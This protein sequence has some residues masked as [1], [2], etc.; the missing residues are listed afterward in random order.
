VNLFV[1]PLGLYNPGCTGIAQLIRSILI[2]YFGFTFPFDIAGIINALLNF[3]LA[4]LAFR[5]LSHKFLAGTAL[6]V[7]VQTLV[8]TLVPIPTV[9]LV[10]DT[11]IGC[12]IGATLAAVGIGLTLM[13]GCSGGGTDILGIYLTLMHPNFSVG[14]LT[15]LVDCFIYFA[16]ALLF[17]LQTSIY[18][19]FYAVIFSLVLDKVHFQNRKTYCMIFT[20][21]S[22]VRPLIINEI[23]RGLTW[24]KGAGGWSDTP[25]EV[26]VSVVSKKEVSQLTRKIH[27]IDPAAFII[28]T[29]DATVAGNFEKRLIL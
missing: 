13:A 15:L 3:P 14:K 6:S 18:S 24:W 4:F 20:R 26:L 25:T 5:Q 29:E 9:P 21:N 8:F 22:N 2:S 16:S 27:A 1:V 10:S 11:A 19:I 28:K 12:A 17:S 7:V 23:H